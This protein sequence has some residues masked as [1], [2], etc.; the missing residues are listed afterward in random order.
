MPSMMMSGS[1]ESETE[2]EP[3]MRM[4]DPVPLVPLVCVT[5]TFAARDDSKSFTPLTIIVGNESTVSAA[6]LFPVSRWRS[7]APVALMVTWSRRVTVAV[8]DA[9]SV[10]SWPA[11]TCTLSSSAA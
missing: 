5:V 8:S 10:A 4:R 1:L 11:L 6:M 7:E 9:S 3:R 2:L